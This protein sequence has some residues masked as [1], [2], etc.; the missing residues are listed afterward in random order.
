MRSFPVKRADGTKGSPSRSSRSGNSAGAVVAA[1]EPLESRRLFSVSLFPVFG[2][3]VPQPY[4]K[5][6]WPPPP[7]GHGHGQ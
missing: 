7:G 5:I 3:I 1:V 2:H 4:G 6:H